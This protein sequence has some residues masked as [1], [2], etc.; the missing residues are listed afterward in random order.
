MQERVGEC[1]DSPDFSACV[2]GTRM[3]FSTKYD[4]TEELEIETGIKQD[5]LLG[6][7]ISLMSNGM[8]RELLIRE[9]H[10]EGVL[11]SVH[12]NTRDRPM[13]RRGNQ[14][15]V[16]IGGSRRLEQLDRA[17]GGQFFYRF[18]GNNEDEANSFL[19]D[20]DV[21]I[22]SVQRTANGVRIRLVADIYENC[23]VE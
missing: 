7:G 12:F 16:S 23:L 17:K 13:V 21:E 22:M 8:S 3:L 4:S 2:F 18:D 15:Y 19:R 1:K 6:L 10:P 14:Q 9:I 5:I 20:M 11:F